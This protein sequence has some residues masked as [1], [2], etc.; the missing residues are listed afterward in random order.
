MAGRS[1]IQLERVMR[2]VEI[3]GADAVAI[4]QCM[5]AF[6][7]ETLVPV[8]KVCKI[9]GEPECEAEY[10]QFR[11]VARTDSLNVLNSDGEYDN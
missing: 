3:N 5:C 7:R 2:G 8:S 4:G 11:K 1:E 6:A 9:S 10:E